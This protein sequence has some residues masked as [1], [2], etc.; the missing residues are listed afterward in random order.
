MSEEIYDKKFADYLADL[1]KN[2]IVKIVDKD[3]AAEDEA[4]RKSGS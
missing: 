2:A 3:L 4:Q 1:R